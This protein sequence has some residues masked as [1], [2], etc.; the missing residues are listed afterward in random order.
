[1]ISTDYE[2]CT[3]CGACVQKCPQKCIEW[4][5]GEF[6]FKY[7]RVDENK[8]VACGLCDKVCPIG[9]NPPRVGTQ[10][11]YALVTNN[12]SVLMN[13]TSG[14]AFSAFA[15]ST[16]ND[17]GVVY[18][19]AMSP[20]FQV[21][22]IRIEKQSEISKLRGSKYVQSDMR[23]CF[24]RISED[25]KSGRK[26]FFTGTPC[27][28]A[29]LYGFLNKNS[30]HLLTAD[31]I[32]HG[33]GSQ[34]YF[35][36]YVEWIKTKKEGLER[37]EFRNKK[38]VGWSCGGLLTVKGKDV[39]FYNHEHYYY[40]YFL[41]GEI[42][43]KSCYSCPY[44]NMNR[45]GDITLGDFWGAEGLNIGFDVSEGCS[46]VIVNSDKGKEAVVRLGEAVESKVVEKQDAVR[47]NEQLTSPS[48][49]KDSRAIRLKEYNTLNGIEIQKKYEKT[50]M[51]RLLK[52]KIKT[53]LPYSVK[54]KLRNII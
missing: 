53:L 39:P 10:T 50:H 33:V 11:V 14:G 35:D 5:P 47:K 23:D 25:L 9:K 32:C 40:S 45:I 30:E 4:V 31:I 36:K 37:I 3:G 12:K 7:P 21:Q 51:S 15:E 16:L 22:H 26:V 8:C 41:S 18:G 44:A 29:G 2:S 52:G 17:G 28:V 1:M 49:Y 43:R 34:A 27:Q 46:L 54:A 20:D 42:Y 19:C 24:N 38:Y 6:G 13:S 48:E